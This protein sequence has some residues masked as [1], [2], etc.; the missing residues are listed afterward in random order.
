MIALVGGVSLE[1]ISAV[2]GRYTRVAAQGNVQ[3]FQYCAVAKHR[4]A[5]SKKG[6]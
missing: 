5:R 6:R 3:G 1:H 2:V 4:S